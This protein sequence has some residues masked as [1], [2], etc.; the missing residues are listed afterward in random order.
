MRIA[1]EA[2]FYRNAKTKYE[3]TKIPKTVDSL[4]LSCEKDIAK[5]TSLN[6]CEI[7]PS[8]RSV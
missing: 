5:N 8:K 3:N 1:S 4:T 6:I 2:T 7:K